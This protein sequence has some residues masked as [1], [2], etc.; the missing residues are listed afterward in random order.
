MNEAPRIGLDSVY[1]AK[2]I[3]DDENGI[4]Y[5]TPKALKGAVNAT[6]NP[7]SSV[8]TDYADNGAFFAT[9]N[10]G[11]TE[12]S[13]E[14]IDVDPDVL[15]EMLGMNSSNGVTVETAMDQSP[16]YAL[17]FRVW[18]AGKD[19]NG[20]NRYELFCYAKGKFSVPETGGATKTDSIDF[21]HIS[22]TAQFV[23]TTYV[24]NGQDSGTICTHCRTDNPSVSAS[25]VANWFSAPTTEL[26]INKNAVTIA[27]ATLDGQT[28]T[29]T[30]AKG[31]GDSFKFAE[32]SVK[33]GD[34]LII[35]QSD[36]TVCT[37]T[38][39]VGS[40]ASTAP[41]IEV[42]VTTGETP[43]YVTVTGGVK[44]VYGVAVTPKTIAL[45]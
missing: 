11:N 18:I 26:V 33:L 16:Y 7:N 5:D 37:G 43:S 4:V 8:E 2:L 24:P 38:V 23:S 13:L 44:D 12:M 20:N 29:I 32:G 10:R 31:D 6:V 28:V 21:R 30:G 39:T 34:T 22:V 19:G 1:I 14:M 35:T 3:S 25:V 41:T 36:G 15:A 42:A 17:M 27:S 45:A 9:S 40:T